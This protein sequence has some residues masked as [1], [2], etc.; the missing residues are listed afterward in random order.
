MKRFEDMTEE[1]ILDRVLEIFEAS[2]RATH[3][4]FTEEDIARYLLLVRKSYQCYNHAFYW[5]RESGCIVGFVSLI[6]RYI[7]MLYV[8]PDYFG[9]GYGRV[10]LDIAL[11]EYRAD[12]LCVF[13]QNTRAL[14][15]YK[16]RGFAVERRIEATKDGEPYPV[17]HMRMQNP[18]LKVVDIDPSMDEYDELLQAG[19]CSLEKRWSY[20]QACEVFGLELDGLPVGVAVVNQDCRIMNFFVLEEYQK[21]YF[22]SWLMTFLFERYYK[23]FRWLQI[24]VSGD[25][26]PYF[27]C[28]GFKRVKTE[29]D[30]YRHLYRH[31]RRIHRKRYDPWDLVY[32][33]SKIEKLFY[34]N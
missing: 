21:M 3:T 9:K 28:F 8:H 12:T 23:R 32:M 1:E 7:D 34:F 20:L 25:K 10:L 30:Y 31:S 15:M 24:A 16:K 5:N 17:L 22:D 29:K 4:F 14:E 6:G 11:N 26:V 19:D 18:A 13:E 33:K 27:K 2:V